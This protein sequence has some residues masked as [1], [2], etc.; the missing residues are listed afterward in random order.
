MVETLTKRTRT[1]PAWWWIY[2]ALVGTIALVGLLAGVFGVYTN[3]IQDREDRADR[4]EA[5]RQSKRFDACFQLFASEFATRSVEVS[6]AQEVVDRIET[7][8]DAAAALR[9]AA[10]Q[11]LITLKPSSDKATQRAAFKVLIET[12]GHLADDRAELVRAREKLQAERDEHPVPDPPVSTDTCV[13]SADQE[14]PNE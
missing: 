9:D 10:L 13:T 6:A 8:A 5:D 7:R 4:L 14:D 12:N 11:D 2:A 1:V 3:V